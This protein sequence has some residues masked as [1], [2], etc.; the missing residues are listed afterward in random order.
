[1]T[2]VAVTPAGT[3]VSRAIA[4]L[5]AGPADSTTIAHRVLGLDRATRAVAERVAVALLGAHPQV[6]RLGDGRWSL[7]AAGH[8]APALTALSFAVVDVETTGHSPARGDRITE[9]GIATLVDGRAELV[10]ERLVNPGRPIPAVV[11]SITRVTDEMVRREPPFEAVADDVVAALAGRV[12]VA[13]NVRFDWA[14]LAAELRRARDVQ[15]RGPMLC[16]VELARRLVPGLRHR[17]LDA[18]AQYFGITIERRH[19]AGPDALATAQVLERLLG[20]AED[21][22]VRTLDELKALARAGRRKRRRKRPAG[23]APMETDQ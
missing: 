6:R 20:L 11:R 21:E 8:S 4:F 5:G 17:G 15:L 3:L 2:G 16:T 13:H 14:F 1:M 19:R 10:Y 12:F 7:A 9:V 23:P 18:V 22:G